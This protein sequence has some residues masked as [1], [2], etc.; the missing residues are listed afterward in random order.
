M[1]NV[2]ISND[3]LLED[4]VCFLSIH[5]IF[6]LARPSRVCRQINMYLSKADKQIAKTQQNVRRV[7][8]NVKECTTDYRSFSRI[9]TPPSHPLHTLPLQV[10]NHRSPTRHIKRILRQH[11]QTNQPIHH[12]EQPS[13]NIR[14]PT[15]HH[16]P[17]N[18]SILHPRRL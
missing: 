11:P 6:D 4:V 16:T 15:R 10:R 2:D 7:N 9:S 18:K 13:K 14:Q 12:K 5:H 1:V 3:A 17:P 8:I